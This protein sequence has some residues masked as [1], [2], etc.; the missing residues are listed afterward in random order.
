MSETARVAEFVWGL[1]AEAIPATTRAVART[2]IL[3]GLACAIAGR[4][5]PVAARVREWARAQGA[6]S[7][8]LSTFRDV[9]WNE[10]F[11]AKLGFRPL[12]P[13]TLGPTYRA[14]L[15]REAALGLPMQRRVV[16]RLVLGPT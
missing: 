13:A 10:P 9:A 7:I 6:A 2:A 11:Y 8:S 1:R 5:E 15:E 16:M 3:D 4:D 14:L 12:D